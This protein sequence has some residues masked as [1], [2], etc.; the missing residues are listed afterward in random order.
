MKNILKN[1]HNPHGSTGIKKKTKSFREK[2]K[3][4][5]LIKKFDI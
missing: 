5:K 1:P 3:F 2:N 4:L